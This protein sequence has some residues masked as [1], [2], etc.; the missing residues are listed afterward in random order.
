M[1]ITGYSWKI[2]YCKHCGAP[3]G[4]VWEASTKFLSSP[5]NFVGLRL[6]KIIDFRNNILG[7][8]V[9]VIIIIHVAYF[10]KWICYLDFKFDFNYYFLSFTV[11]SI[12]VGMI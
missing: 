11:T 5:I 3:L 1:S 12:N 7:P 4:W 6:D 8:L 9:Q 10:R 2:A